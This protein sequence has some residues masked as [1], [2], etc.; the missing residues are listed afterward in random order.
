MSSDFEDAQ[1]GVETA[2][3][4][5]NQMPS[6]SEDINVQI[7]PDDDQPEHRFVEKGP[8]TM[9]LP[10]IDSIVHQ[11]ATS[12]LY[13]Q[14]EIDEAHPPGSWNWAT[15]MAQYGVIDFEAIAEQT[16]HVLDC[17][18]DMDDIDQHTSQAL[19]QYCQIDD[20]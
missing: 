2:M 18:A 7:I 15:C 12:H 13:S 9:D 10:L 17:G 19:A 3:E 5:E 4:I 8:D 11:M 6:F 1:F 16:D 20:F 14:E